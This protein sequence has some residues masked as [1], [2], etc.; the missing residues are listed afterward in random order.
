LM[1]FFAPGAP[2]T[3]P[4]SRDGRSRC[5]TTTW[6]HSASRFIRMVLIAACASCAACVPF[7]HYEQLS[8]DIS[9]SVTRHNKPLPGVIVL[10]T[11]GMHSDSCPGAA[12][13]VVTDSIGNFHF[14]SRTQFRWLYR[15]L[16]MPIAVSSYTVCLNTDDKTHIGYHGIARMSSSDSITLQCNINTPLAHTNSIRQTQSFFCK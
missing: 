5:L 13:T 10:L 4:C 2:L 8:P 12:E 6:Q 3:K 14:P 15:P 11:G 7:P 16:V 1:S 9:G